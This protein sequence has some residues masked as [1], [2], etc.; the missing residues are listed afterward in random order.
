[1][2]AAT[3]VTGAGA[4][5]NAHHQHL[6]VNVNVNGNGLLHPHRSSHSH[7]DLNNYRRRSSAARKSSTTAESQQQRRDFARLSV[8][9][10]ASLNPQQPLLLS[11]IEDESICEGPVENNNNNT[12]QQKTLVH[13]RIEPCSEDEAFQHTDFRAVTANGNGI[14]MSELLNGGTP[15]ANMDSHGPTVLTTAFS[16]ND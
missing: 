10:A 6:Q 7:A 8:I 9:R 16:R 3:A 1:M 11:P 2:C 5:S 12:N 13:L 15:Q 4:N 14:D